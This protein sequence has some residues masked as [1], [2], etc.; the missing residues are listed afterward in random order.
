M[1]FRWTLNFPKALGQDPLMLVFWAVLAPAL[2][3]YGSALIA[4]SVIPAFEPGTAAELQAYQTAWFFNCLGMAAWFAAMSYWSE[5]RGAGPFAGPI[6]MPPNW[7]TITLIVGPILLLVPN[8]I[9]NALMS[10]E[11]WAYRND[12][13]AE[14]LS[15]SNWSLAFILLAVLMAPCAEELAFRGIVLGGLITR[16]VKPEFAA[17]L[18]SAAFAF[19]HMHYTVAGMFVD[20]LAGLGFAALRL[21]S[22]SLLIPIIAHAS[23]NGFILWVNWMTPSV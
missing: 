14:A 2:F 7:L 17:I 3:I 5:F 4:V 22:G 21:L 23:G 16:G 1:K 19:I 8:L 20:F 13:N 10:S 15:P 6:F 18:S 11:Q 9:M 12:V